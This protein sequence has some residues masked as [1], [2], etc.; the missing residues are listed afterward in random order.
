MPVSLSQFFT[1][2]RQFPSKSEKT[3]FAANAKYF[4]C[5]QEAHENRQN[6]KTSGS[7]SPPRYQMPHH[8][9]DLE[10]QIH[11]LLPGEY[12]GSNSRD[13]PGGDA[14]VSN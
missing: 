11:S 2:L 8:M 10:H 4:L 3:V 5:M 13:M 1:K 7:N 14:E 6:F 12:L 9:E